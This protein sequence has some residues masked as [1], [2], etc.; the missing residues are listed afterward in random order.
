ML[1]KVALAGVGAAYLARQC[2]KPSSRVGRVLARGMNASHGRLTRW[3]LSHVEVGPRF[4]VLD[5]GC[6]GGQTIDTLA[7]V[8]TDGKVFGIDYSADSVAVA[9]EKN[10]SWIERARVDIRHG[11]VSRLP[12]PDQTFDL[13]TAVETHY[14]WPDLAG[15]VREV[16]RVLKPGGAF[17]IIAE[18]YRGRRNDWLYRPAM[19]LLRAS[20]L[21]ADEHRN[22]LASAGY[23][24][25]DVFEERSYGW[26]CAL[27]RR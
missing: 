1:G 18:S 2:R 8:A 10:R 25:V 7:T 6:G 19:A 26:I 12:F 21:S 3:G 15:D 16:L 27:G 17:L 14:Y 20:Y 4:T 5:V 23:H 24:D 22:L 13:V 9:R 11:S